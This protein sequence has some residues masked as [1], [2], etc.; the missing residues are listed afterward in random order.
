MQSQILNLTKRNPEAFRT[1]STTT[2]NGFWD[3]ADHAEHPIHRIHAYPAKFPA[4]VATKALEYG[5]AHGLA[6]KRVGDVFCGCGTVAY[7]ASRQGMEFWGC[8]INPV[9]ALIA[10]AK[11]GHYSATRL[12][13]YQQKIV[14]QMQLPG[15]AVQLL[16]ISTQN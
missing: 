7:E 16:L 4:L 6:I 13:S 8:D 3:S 12:R 10:K 5:K 1:L 9:A 14:G 2:S 15:P 11:S